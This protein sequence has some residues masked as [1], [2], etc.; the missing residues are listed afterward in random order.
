MNTST[1]TYRVRT[2]TVVSEN[3]DGEVVAIHLKRGHYYSM[4]GT[5]ALVW[6]WIEAGIPYQVIERRLAEQ[7]ECPDGSMPASVREFLGALLEEGL[8]EETD[9][10][11][12]PS[13]GGTAVTN[14]ATRRPFDPPRLERHTDMQDLLVLDPIHDV[15]E[16]GW[17]TPKDA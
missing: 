6:A 16:T 8:V 11:T 9:Q 7:F 5:A 2:P 13:N 10:A 4:S 3:I 17:P 15:G 14:G 12:S 1:A